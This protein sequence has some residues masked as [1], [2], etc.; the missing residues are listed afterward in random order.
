MSLVH[1]LL[2]T[3]VA[4]KGE[5]VVLH[6][7]DAPFLAGAGTETDITNGRLSFQGVNAV[8]RQLLPEAEQVSFDLHGTISYECPPLA[9]YPG[10]RFSVVALREVDEMWVEI[11]RE[12]GSGEPSAPG[13]GS[14][15]VGAA[16]AV[17][18]APARAP[19]AAPR[20]A[21]L[22]PDDLALPDF[23]ALWPD[24]VREQAP[25]SESWADLELNGDDLDGLTSL[26]GAP[27]P[28]DSAEP[29]HVENHP[30]GTGRA[31]SD[32]SE[33]DLDRLDDQL[34]L[35]R[36]A[37]PVQHDALP[38]FDER[39]IVAGT[40][41]PQLDSSASVDASAPEIHAAPPRQAVVL[42]MARTQ[43]RNDALEP[44]VDLTAGG[45]LRLLRIVAARGGSALYIT[46]DARPAMRVDGEIRM[47]DDQDPLSAADTET[48][49]LGAMP[50][51]THEALRSGDRT[52]WVSDVTDLGRVRCVSFRDHR[53]PGGIFRILTGRAASVEQL[54]LSRE[55][56][57]MA[58]E[59]EG[60]VLVAGPRSS[61]K[62]TLIAAFVDL[63]NRTRRDH[64]IT[65]E[66]EI[67]VVHE[68]H[69]SMISQ[70]EVRGDWPGVLAAART[71]LREDPD[72]LVIEELRDD[73]IT[74]LALDASGSGR[75]VIAGVP[76]HTTLDA[77]DRILDHFPTER[78]R[79]AQ[80][81]LAENLRGIIAQSLLR[82]PGG[83][84]LAAREVL[85]NTPA[86]ASLIA[87]GKTAQLPMAIEVG[88]TIGMMSLNESLAALVKSSAVDV[89]EAYRRASDRP[90]L[91]ALLT[92]HGIDTTLLERLA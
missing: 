73:A 87:E 19:A 39:R 8:L 21:T 40:A 54:G 78:R 23:E 67:Q 61:G 17:A 30:A 82:K 22:S 72:V 4:A 68:S 31:W 58:L 86:V 7:G 71:A 35:T 16:A 25:G 32:L 84:R 14:T 92:R 64:V 77:I 13:A 6:T 46:S 56:R 66:N 29:A 65:I 89:R 28:R 20:A 76:A 59:P 47:L 1:R 15:D 37:S 12:S 50:K 90:G 53:G 9:A 48:L 26:A 42:P 70:R 75:L 38:A 33:F 88:R 43:I 36:L 27:A 52:E 18:P 10:E 81:A 5:A 74:D 80:L 45:L 11:R 57:A 79:Q 85:L 51:R 69:G 34:P 24:Q 41:Q 60:L 91:L 63:I 44:L 62:S 83:G 55:V 2:Q 49:L 3:I